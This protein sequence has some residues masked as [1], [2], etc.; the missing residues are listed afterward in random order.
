VP[1]AVQLVYSKADVYHQHAGNLQLIVNSYN[2]LLAS[3]AEVI[4]SGTQILGILL[5]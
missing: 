3:M 5:Q 4:P 2:S 1:D